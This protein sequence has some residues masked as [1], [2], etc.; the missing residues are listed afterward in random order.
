MGLRVSTGKR[1]ITLSRHQTE[2]GYAD[3]Y[4]FGPCLLR[5]A[6]MGA[7]DRAR[8]RSDVETQGQGCAKTFWLGTVEL[9]RKT[10]SEKGCAGS[11]WRAW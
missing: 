5:P 8:A 7:G 6:S 2:P 3:A 9:E 1:Q 11:E 4:Q 10:G